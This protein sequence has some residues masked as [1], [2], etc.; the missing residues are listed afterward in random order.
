MEQWRKGARKD[1][2]EV[3]VGNEGL[4]MRTKGDELNREDLEV[5]DLCR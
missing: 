1:N 5:G 4:R 2:G 3:F